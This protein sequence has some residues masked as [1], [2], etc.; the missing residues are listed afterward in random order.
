M[1]TKREQELIKRIIGQYGPIIHLK[2]EPGVLIE[3]LREF[4][5]NIGDVLGE[6]GTGGGGGGP[7]VSSIAIAGP[8]SGTVTMEDV[9]RLILELRQ[10][11]IKLSERIARGG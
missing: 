3:I 5:P 9:F 2:K 8:G 4:G 6:N 10:E 7:G 1:P 11:I